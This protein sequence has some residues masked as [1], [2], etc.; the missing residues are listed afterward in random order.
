MADIVALIYA[1]HDWFRRQFF[2]LDE[3]TTQAEQE[4]GP[5]GRRSPPGWTP[6]A[7]AEETVFYPALLAKG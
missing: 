4:G 6:T 1:D 2:A 5:S 3:A 7:Q